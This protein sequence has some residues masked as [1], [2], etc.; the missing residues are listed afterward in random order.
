MVHRDCQWSVGLVDGAVRE[1]GKLLKGF[2]GWCWNHGRCG[3]GVR[4]QLSV[5]GDGS[6]D[7]FAYDED[8][9]DA[10]VHCFDALRNL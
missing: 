1:D 9:L 2:R 7:W 8:Q 3:G 5:V 6:C 10:R 4:A